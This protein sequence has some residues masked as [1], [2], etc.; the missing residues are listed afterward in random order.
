MHAAS[1]E[2]LALLNARLDEAVASTDTVAVAA[3]TGSELFDVVEVLDS[4][5]GLRV[6]VADQ[7]ATAEKRTEIIQSLFTG[8]VS[9][10]TLKVVTDAVAQAW[11]TPREL[12]DGLVSLGRRALLRSA[13]AQGQ[14]ETVESE[15]FQLSVLLVKQPQ[16]EQLLADKSASADA[17]RGLFASVLYGKVTSVTE[18]LA[19]QAVAR[20]QKRPAD[21]LE[22]LSRQ[23][24]AL[25]DRVVARVTSATALS[26]QQTEALTEKLGRI[27]GEQVSIHSVI[28][29]S[30]LGGLVVRVGDEVIDG[31][32]A[33]K[34]EKLRV[35]LG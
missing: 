19:L 34:L 33:G 28:D 3:Q 30:V 20:P 14:L 32:L 7:S 4:D 21:D 2:S 10:T 16:F 8:K 25:R 27:Y 18:I 31:S 6:A 17:K 12:R 13:E 35:G 24:A 9:E 22:A 15:L 11:S 29:K 5:R 1:R 23:A 26:D